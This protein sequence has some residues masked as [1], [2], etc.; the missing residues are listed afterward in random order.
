MTINSIIINTYNK[1]LPILT[2]G[3][4]PHKLALTIAISISMGIV[5]L[6]GVNSVACA[7]IAIIWGLN[8]PLMQILMWAFFPLQLFLYMKFFSL[9]SFLFNREV[10]SMTLLQFWDLLKS[11]WLLALQKFALGNL[12]AIAA[13]AIIS[14]PLTI[15]CY[16]LARFVILKTRK[17]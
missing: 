8:V 1:L 10:F 3:T 11:D 14:I 9:A 6:L 16:Y 2:Q 15:A 7:A 12:F 5:P 13:W 17:S 4:T